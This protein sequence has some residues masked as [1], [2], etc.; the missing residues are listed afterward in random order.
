MSAGDDLV[1]LVRVVASVVVVIALVA[2]TARLARRAGVRGPG[3][4]L[5]V[6]ERAG[7]SKEASVAVVEVGGKAL[8]LGVTAQQVSVLSELD[9]AELAR[10]VAAQAVAAR[11]VPAQQAAPR[12]V[13]APQ[14]GR[15]A[16]RQASGSVLSPRTWSQGVEALR[17]LT[18]R[19]TP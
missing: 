14:D 15:P 12:R 10:T 8:V 19:R 7:L 18:T 16:A 6:L 3:A 9:A 5:R 17:D 1:A 4:G 13:V 2:L 11:T